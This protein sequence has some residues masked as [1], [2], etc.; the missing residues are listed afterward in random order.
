[1][2]LTGAQV[3][4][5]TDWAKS[6]TDTSNLYEILI[7]TTRRP[8]SSEARAQY[9]VNE[10]GVS[11]IGNKIVVT[12]WNEKAIGLAVDLFVKLLESSVSTSADGGKTISFL[13]NTK[14]GRLKKK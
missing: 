8:E 7:G 10:Y 3:S 1:M 6:G 14:V 2:K 5:A 4:I 13:E 11:I 9:G 12:G